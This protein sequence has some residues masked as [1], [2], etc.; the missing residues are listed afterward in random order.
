MNTL[1]CF[2]CNNEKDDMLILGCKHALCLKCSAYTLK[3]EE[4]FNNYKLIKCKLCEE[5]TTI[6]EETL[7]EIF[8]YNLSRSSDINIKTEDYSNDDKYSNYSP[9]QSS[10]Q[11]NNN[12]YNYTKNDVNKNAINITK[13]QNSF[14]FTNSTYHNKQNKIN[15]NEL[16]HKCTYNNLNST[17]LFPILKE[18]NINYNYSNNTTLLSTD[19]IIKA[20]SNKLFCNKHNEELSYFCFDCFIKCICSECVVHGEHKNHEVLNIKKAYPI[21]LEKANEYILDLTSKT[22]DISCI[23]SSLESKKKEINI[24]SDNLKK[25][26]IR[27]FD[28]IKQRLYKKEKEL[29]EKIELFKSEQ[30]QEINTFSRIIQGKLIT[31]NKTIDNIKSS[32]LRKNEAS[33]INY[34][35]E[36]KLNIKKFLEEDLIVNINELNTIN[37]VKVNINPESLNS[38]ISG[39]NGVHLEISNL[40]GLEISKNENNNYLN[41]SK[42]YNCNLFDNN[43]NKYNNSLQ[44]LNFLVDKQ[45]NFNKFHN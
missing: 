17:K 10:N 30:L 9:K 16:Q 33:F 45:C 44:N 41:L 4:K 25:E 34:F 37:G 32:L 12:F 29:L 31:L 42:Y 35:S 2:L 27:A 40:S 39:L 15:S 13:N 6:E 38:M 24:T 3:E 20:N 22:T 7:N 36:N 21:I 5:A 23:N 18:N 11:C 26:T 19:N 28:D 8:N 14:D 1:L 43:L